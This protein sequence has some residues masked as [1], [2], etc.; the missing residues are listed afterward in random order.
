MGSGSEAVDLGEVWER[1]RESTGTGTHLARLDPVLDLN[2][3]IRQPDGSLGLLLRVEEV[4]PF[5]VSELTGSEQVDIEHET[6]DAT[7]S[8]RL[9]LLKTESTEIFLKLCED[10]VPKI[11]AQDTQIAAA[12]VLVRRFNTWQRFM[13]RSQG[14]GLSASRQ[15]GLYGELVTLKELMIPAVGLTRAVESWTGPEN[16]PQDFQASGIGIETKT[17]V[18]REPQQLRISGERQLDDIGLD[19]LVLTHHRIVQ[20]RGAGETLPELVEAVSDL[21]AEAEG[22]LDLFEDKLFAAGYA[23]FDRQEY[24]QTGYSLRETSYYRV[25]PGFPRL[26]EN[27]LFPGIGALSYTVD[28]SACAAFAVDAE[29][30]SSWFTEPPPVVDPAVSNEGHQVEYK[31]TAWT[32]VGEPKNDDHRQK[33]ERDLKNSV[34]K[35]VVAFL[36]SDGGELVIGVRNEDHA[37]TGI[38]LDL[39][40]REKE[41]DDHDYY[42]REL[43][44]L[45]SD[46][47]DNRVHNQL[48]VRFESHEEGTTCHVSVRPSPSP[49]FGTTPSPHEK[50]RPKFWIRALNTTK[51]LEGN[52]ILG[53]IEEHWS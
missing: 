18:Q 19:A 39:E 1:L 10:L 33:L 9:Q 3:T 24:L 51:E 26:T 6:D 14:R 53:W 17:L 48:R 23:P 4:V 37:V 2:A 21:I 15:R 46:R 22:P 35:T 13:K 8:I 12:T 7:T 11:I 44:N 50:T 29:T 47:I 52:D 25:Q 41:T 31:Q 38:E 49:R 45:F 5:E 20:H 30:V 34:V 16:R 36:N 43:V 27:D 32:P 40:A 28:A 42:E